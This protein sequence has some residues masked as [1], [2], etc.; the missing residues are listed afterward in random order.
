LEELGLVSMPTFDAND[1]D[2]GLL[3]RITD[4]VL[5][6]IGVTRPGTAF[7]CSTQ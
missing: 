4:Q 6:D 7:A 2:S 1:I 3:P 5:K